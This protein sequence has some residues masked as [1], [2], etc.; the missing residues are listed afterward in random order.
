[1]PRTDRLGHFRSGS[2]RF[3]HLVT[4]WARLSHIRPGRACL[5]RLSQSN[6]GYS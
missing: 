1:M 4:V 5:G 3:G 6:P 2:A